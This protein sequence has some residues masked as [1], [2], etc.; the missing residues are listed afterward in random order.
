MLFCQTIFCFW[1][2]DYLFGKDLLTVQQR[3]KGIGHFLSITIA[4]LPSIEENVGRSWSTKTKESIVV[5][6]KG[7]SFPCSWLLELCLNIPTITPS[8]KRNFGNVSGSSNPW[9]LENLWKFVRGVDMRWHFVFH[10]T[11]NSMEDIQTTN[12]YPRFYILSNKKDES[13]ASPCFRFL[14]AQRINF[15]KRVKSSMQSPSIS[16]SVTKFCTISWQP[17]QRPIN[18]PPS[19]WKQRFFETKRICTR[20]S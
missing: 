10:P 13:T 2:F 7:L 18:S 5:R 11:K 20:W 4:A 12:N 9:D 6:K 14:G 8:S 3:K 15:T 16:S 19:D 17:N 1:I